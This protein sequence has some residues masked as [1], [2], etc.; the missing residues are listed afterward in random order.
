[1][2]EATEQNAGTRPAA[3]GRFYLPELDVLR[4]FAFFAVFVHH[5]PAP[6][7]P[8]FYN[9]PG[10]IGA[11]GRS[12]A[13]G[14]D[15]FFT[16]SGYLITRLL[17]RE[18]EET[19]DIKLGAFY[20][21]RTL[22]IWPL[23]YFAIGLAFLLTHLPVS[24]VS[25]PPYLGRLFVP[26]KPNAY[27]FMATFLYNFNFFDCGMSNPMPLMGLLWSV[28]VEEQFYLF[29]PWFVRYVP[30]RRI[31]IIPIVMI[32][33]AFITRAFLT[34]DLH[35]L[36]WNYTFARLDPIAVGI[37]IALIPGLNPGRMLRP[38]LVLFGI[39]SWLFAAGWCGLPYEHD[40]LKISIG[41]P[42]IALGSGAF[43]LAA[44]GAKNLGRISAPVRLLVYL[45]KISYGLYVYNTIAYST[46]ALLV[47]GRLLPESGRSWPA[48]S[49]YAI[50]AFGLNV[51]FAAVSYRW[52]E[53]PF[54]RLKKR[55]TRVPSGAI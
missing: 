21:R 35:R 53:S 26:M 20:A 23:Y 30:R 29:W 11:I 38:I 45:G 27:L 41:Y 24:I 51:A 25:A 39:A 54:L 48:L 5:I 10:V 4:F 15:L 37:L 33:V 17:L 44:L 1:V 14:V 32:A 50:A 7:S 49:L 16:L 36:L 9:G 31:V 13:F 46:A 2:S 6:F 22:R 34:F 55:F 19:G 40:I 42:A 18:R 28:S 47:L 43:L 12:G 3:S 52:L 8:D